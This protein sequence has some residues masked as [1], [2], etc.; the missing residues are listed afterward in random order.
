MRQVELW[1]NDYESSPAMNK[2]TQ[3]HHPP[4]AVALTAFRQPSSL[5]YALD[6]SD[7]TS[8]LATPVATTA[9]IQHRYNHVHHH[10]QQQQQQ[11]QQQSET[12]ANR[13]D[14]AYVDGG[15]FS[16][17]QPKSFPAFQ[18]SICTQR[19]NNVD[20]SGGGRSDF[21]GGA[22]V[23]MMWTLLPDVVS[24]DPFSTVS[25]TAR[26]TQL[27]PL[28]PYDAF[29]QQPNWMKAENESEQFAASIADGRG[30]EMI[31]VRPHGIR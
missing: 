8:F 10:Q 6:S 20:S 24:A 15:A 13:S 12:F 29:Q 19:R 30:A 2:W 28:P 9:D 7:V 17:A 23:R 3:R 31:V 14:A 26:H 11:Q 21:S 22:A 5:K 25:S 4:T 27:K 1:T 16:A 18:S